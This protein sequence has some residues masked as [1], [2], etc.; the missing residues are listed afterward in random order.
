MPGAHSRFIWKRDRLGGNLV[1]ESIAK[2]HEIKNY[3]KYLEGEVDK[4]KENPNFK[5]HLN[6]VRWIA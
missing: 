6:T 4:L 2:L 1:A 3:L 5:L